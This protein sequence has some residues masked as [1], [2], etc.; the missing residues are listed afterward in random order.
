MRKTIIILTLG[1]T[2]GFGCITV[3]VPP[4]VIETKETTTVYVPAPEPT[5]KPVEPKKVKKVVKKK[6]CKPCP[7]I[8]CEKC[9]IE[10]TK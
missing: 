4:D 10:D 6:T 8:T 2:L 1:M 9:K 5:T 3:A 7:K